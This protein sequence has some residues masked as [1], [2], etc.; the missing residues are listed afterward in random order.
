MRT[1]A[2]EGGWPREASLSRRDLKDLKELKKLSKK[3]P[4]VKGNNQTERAKWLPE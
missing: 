2:A 1:Q 4:W 3:D